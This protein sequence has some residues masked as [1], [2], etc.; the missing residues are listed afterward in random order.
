MPVYFNAAQMLRS[1]TR[2]L[3]AD[4]SYLHS[5]TRR[6]AG[7]PLAGSSVMVGLS[8]RLAAD[9]AAVEQEMADTNVEIGRYETAD[10]ALAAIR[11]RL[12]DMR[13]LAD[14]AF[15]GAY[16]EEQ[17]EEMDAEYQALAGEIEGLLAGTTYNG[18][19]VLSGSGAV[20][21]LDFSAVTDISLTDLP[22]DALTNLSLAVV[23][24]TVARGRIAASL[25][26]FED[27]LVEL[28]DHQVSLTAFG[29]RIERT[30]LTLDVLGEVVSSVQAMFRLAAEAQANLDPQRASHVLDLGYHSYF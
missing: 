9:V 25:S 27:A 14:Q 7:G 11:E 3:Y 20:A 24:T 1:V 26:E 4:F 13:Q 10:A 16:T 30:D 15:S 17:V 23:D 19:P 22:D 21:S 12:L 6:L 28:A 8:D 18:S 5:A 2:N 29:T